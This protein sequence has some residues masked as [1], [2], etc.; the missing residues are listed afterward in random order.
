MIDPTTLVP[1]VPLVMPNGLKMTVVHAVGGVISLRCNYEPLLA[2][3]STD[4]V[5]VWNNATLDTDKA[6]RL[7]WWLTMYRT[8]ALVAEVADKTMADVR[9]V[10]A[11]KG[12]AVPDSITEHRNTTLT[13]I[14]GKLR[15]IGMSEVEAKGILLMVNTASCKPPLATGEVSA[16]IGVVYA[17]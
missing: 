3:Y 8:Q 15:C 6:T 12:V 13:S 10:L 16:I 14:A 1:G 5:A 2:S 9:N 7:Y 4:D 17:I 11:Y